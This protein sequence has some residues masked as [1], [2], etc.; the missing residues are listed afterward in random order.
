MF[1]LLESDKPGKKIP[2]G[3]ISVF[4]GTTFSYRNADTVILCCLYNRTLFIKP[5]FIL[6]SENNLFISGKDSDSVGSKEN[7]TPTPTRQPPSAAGFGGGGLFEDDDDDDDF[8]SGKST[9]KSESGEC[10]LTD[11]LLLLEAAHLFSLCVGRLLFQLDRR[12]PRNLLT[13]LPTMMRMATSSV[14]STAYQLRI[15]KMEQLS[16]PNILRRR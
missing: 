2:A 10:G 3:G 11:K 12:R 7:G 15:R 6:S 8:F 16:P 5:L 14:R 4:P 13:F 9:K 1:F